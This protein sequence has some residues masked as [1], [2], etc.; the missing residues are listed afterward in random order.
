[1]PPRQKLGASSKA[2]Q[3]TGVGTEMGTGDA[4]VGEG[5]RVVPGRRLGEQGGF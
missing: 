5:Q 4:L 2:G 1:M 3:G